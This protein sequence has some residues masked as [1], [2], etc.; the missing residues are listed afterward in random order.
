[1]LN[2]VL[3]MGR[4]TRDP[5]LRQTP[6]GTSVTSFTLAV[7][8]DFKSASGNRDADFIDCVAW[9]AAAEF[10]TRSFKKGQ[11]AAVD[12]RLQIRSWMAQDGNNRYRAEVVVDRLYFAERR[13][14][15]SERP[16][17]PEAGQFSEIPGD[18]K[19]ELPF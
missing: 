3:L 11:L 1:M 10:A 5:E 16:S 6:D 7:D 15:I 4:L 8:R 13:R 19:G 12:G 17:E 14:D 2:R 9:R 18:E